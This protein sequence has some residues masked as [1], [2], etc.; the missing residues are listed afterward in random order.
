M[1]EALKKKEKRKRSQRQSEDVTAG[2]A[3]CLSVSALGIRNQL[4]ASLISLSEHMNVAEPQC[5][6]KKSAIITSANSKTNAF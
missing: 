1:F 4:L 5:P 3:A 2:L 6:T